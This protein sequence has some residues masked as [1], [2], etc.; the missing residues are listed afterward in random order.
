L[1][2][3]FGRVRQLP[4]LVKRKAAQKADGQQHPYEQ[5]AFWLVP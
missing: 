5:S 2:L 1:K 4:E 3:G